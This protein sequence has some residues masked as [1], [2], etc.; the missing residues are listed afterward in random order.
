RQACPRC[1]LAITI[2]VR[3]ALDFSVHLRCSGCSTLLSVSS[4]TGSLIEAARDA[5]ESEL[6]GMV[7]IALADGVSNRTGERPVAE[8]AKTLGLAEDL[9][10]TFV[11]SATVTKGQGAL[12]E[13]Y[14]EDLSQ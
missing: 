14:E 13:V 5:A 4:R 7:E 1:S 12:Q 10:D 3:P 9:L 6:K 11:S 2:D 8:R